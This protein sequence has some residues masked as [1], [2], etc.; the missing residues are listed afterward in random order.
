MLKNIFLT[1]DD[2]DDREVFK[3]ALHDIDETIK[4]EFATN[5]KETIERLKDCNTLPDIIFLDLNMP[6]MNGFECLSAL[7]N[8]SRLVTLPVVIFTTSSNPL[9]VQA[10]HQLGANVFLIKPVSI[11]ELTKKLQRILQINFNAGTDWSS[12]A[13]YSV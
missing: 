12:L 4:F 11:A 13:Q 7:K 8:D 5:G 6:I 3:I 10:T 2:D 1:E 9:D